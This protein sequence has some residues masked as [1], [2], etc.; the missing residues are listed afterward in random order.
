MYTVSELAELLD[1]EISTI[2][3]WIYRG[4]LKSVSVQQETAG[5]YTARRRY[6]HLI[7]DEALDNFLSTNPYYKKQFMLSRVRRSQKVARDLDRKI[8]NIKA[9][10]KTLEALINEL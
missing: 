6:K 10:M 8:D 9:C 4:K 7:E 1:V 3:A 2:M 5:D